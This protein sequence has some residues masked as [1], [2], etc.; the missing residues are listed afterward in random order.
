MTMSVAQWDYFAAAVPVTIVY[1]AGTGNFRPVQ[2]I[3]S[4]TVKLY[5]WELKNGKHTFTQGQIAGISFGS[6]AVLIIIALILAY[7]SKCCY[8]KKTEQVHY[9]Q[10]EKND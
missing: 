1:T 5:L 7:I 9:E 3:G 2:A 10:A 6:L 8:A 4:R